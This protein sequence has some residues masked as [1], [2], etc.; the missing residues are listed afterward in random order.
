MCT[1]ERLAALWLAVLLVSAAA[2]AADDG[3]RLGVAATAEQIAAWDISIPPDGSGLPAGLGNVAEGERV[4]AAKC[5][6]CHGEAGRGEPNDALAGGR[7][8]LASDAP[9]RTVGSYWPYATTLFDYIRRAMPLLQPQS[10]GND[11]VYALTAYIL[12]LNGIVDGNAVMDARSLPRVVMPNR[13]GFI[14]VYPRS[15]AE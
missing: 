10:L 7:G 5:Q 3:P 4:Y 2:T 12:S 13:G 9:V 14:A 15:P 8:T 6:S 1:P 11:E